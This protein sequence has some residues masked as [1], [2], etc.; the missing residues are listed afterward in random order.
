MAFATNYANSD[1][2][3]PVPEG[4]YEVLIRKS[5]MGKDRNDAEIVDMQLVIRND[6]EQGQKNRI[7]FNALRRVSADKLTESDKMCDG[8]FSPAVQGLSKAAQLP[9]GKS[10]DSIAE[11]AKDLL[12]KPIRVTV[13]HSTGR[14]GK[15]F[16]NARYYN[17]TKFPAVNHVPKDIAQTSGGSAGGYTAPA[18]VQDDDLPF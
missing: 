3:A 9:E 4:E 18:Q 10:Y 7:I 13:K 6:V 8:F 14:D 2:N 16:V 1:S 11:W 5:E 15:V 12:G 17:P